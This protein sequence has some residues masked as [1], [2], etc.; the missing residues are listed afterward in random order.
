MGR[1]RAPVAHGGWGSGDQATTDLGY[2]LRPRHHKPAFPAPMKW[3]FRC[4]GLL[5][6]AL[7][8]TALSQPGPVPAMPL[9]LSPPWV[10]AVPVPVPEQPAVD[11]VPISP[12]TKSPE[13]PVELPRPVSRPERVVWSWP[14]PKA[15]P[16][17]VVTREVKRVTQPTR[18]R[19]T[20]SNHRSTDGIHE[21]KRDRE[22]RRGDR[23]RGHRGEHDEHEGGHG[24]REHSGRGEGHSRD[25]GS[26]G[27]G[28]HGGRPE[29]GREGHS[30][31]RGDGDSGG[32]GHESGD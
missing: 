25:E 21:S 13:L 12:R 27:D 15:E 18:E 3:S 29:G 19:D 26:H 5:P 16:E 23:D 31:G 1:H 8:F 10:T 9:P 32:H 11:E 28:D 24:G 4:A 22:H 30:E 7:A 20:D 17:R 2:E 6:A 14:L